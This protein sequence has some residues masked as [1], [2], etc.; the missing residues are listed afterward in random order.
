MFSAVIALSLLPCIAVTI[1]PADL[2]RLLQPDS[3]LVFHNLAELFSITVSL[4]I[5][6]AAWYTFDQSR[7]QHVLFLG[8]AF[9]VIALLDLMHTLSFAGMPAFATPNS[10]DKA[11]EF[12]IM[13][14]LI[15]AAA[16]LGSAFILPGPERT[17]LSKPALMTS[18][19][20]AVLLA[21]T[22]IFLFPAGLPA[23]YLEGSG[24]T[25][26]KKGAE[27]LIIVL[28]AAAGAFYW[29]RFRRTGD[30]VL[31]FFLAALLLSIWSELVLVLRRSVYDT[32]TGLGHAY[33]VIAFF[34][35]YKG[36]I[37]ASVIR[38]YARLAE[39]GEQLRLDILKRRQI[40]EALGA[41]KERYR[42]IAENV[43][44]VIWTLDLASRKFSYVSPSVM[45]L[46]GYS[47]EEV[48][49]QP[50]E[51]ILTPGSLALVTDRLDQLISGLANGMG[52]AAGGPLEVEQPC[53]DGSTVWTEVS[54]SVVRD[55][56][57]RPTA[58]LGISRNITERKRAEKAL[59]DSEQR[60]RHLV[61]AVTDS[62]YSARVENGRVVE[63]VHSPGCR[64]ITGYGPE[65][66]ASDPLF[67]HQVVHPEDREAVEAHMG[68]L[69]EHKAG[70]SFEH[71]IVHLDGSIRWIK[72]TT[73]PRYDEQG[74]LAGWD[75]LI[76]DITARKKLEEQLR[77][78]QKM[79]AIGQLAGGIAHDF[80]NILSAIVG[81]GSLLQMRIGTDDAQ[82]TNIDQILDAA[83]RASNLTHSL[84]AFSR[85]QVLKQEPVDL[86]GIVRRVE[87]LLRRIMGE[88]VDIRTRFWL[89]KAVV[90]ADRGQIEQVLMNLA[91]NA[92]DAMPR[93]G[94]F[95][96]ETNRA[97]VDEAFLHASGIGRPG[98]F[99]VLSVS[100]TGIGM[101]EA[102]RKKVF[103]PFF[104]TKEPGK[105]TGLGLAMVYGI[106][107]QHQGFLTMESEPGQ[108][109]SCRIYV[110]L[111]D[112]ALESVM[113]GRRREPAAPPPTGT[114][115]VLVAED[116]D[117]LRELSGT[118]LRES[119]YT[120]I[121]A[122]DGQEAVDLFREHAG[123]IKMVLLDMIMPKMSG[124]DAFQEIRRINADVKAL[125]LSGY[126]ADNIAEND[127]L[128]RQ[129]DL[130]NKPVVPRDLLTK[131][132]EVLDA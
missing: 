16:L 57:G 26:F 38:P 65:R 68:G 78:A 13:A 97:E 17:W 62:I 28:L 102:T 40:E 4:S 69:L 32:Y 1:F 41:S 48:M 116:D 96:I 80:N 92:R 35:I 54:T 120:V 43:S 98:T 44:D 8:A 23:A 88:D 119:G 15:S 107:E 52:L 29:I 108:G 127:G 115:T 50:L 106:V 129:A 103:E 25:T 109:T 121:P 55:G 73:A 56:Q 128:I 60:Y 83:E 22:A 113:L 75:G 123:T 110:P 31:L 105:G 19:V 131:V 99:A 100:D 86:N 3:C 122:R 81:Y 77:Q 63:T 49:E 95:L 34:L 9:L 27:Y 37:S 112:P 130:I 118:L 33:K 72:H 20:A 132:R 85:K 71:R 21:F 24:L 53:K 12:W 87:K 79:E 6:G 61:E 104:T 111:L 14:R 5:F 51:R 74:K 11:T 93:G 46:R 42:L 82:R 76:L 94:S 70:G 101:D 39:T 89:D 125:F 117:C 114:E 59:L 45:K 64:S 58:I 2:Y 18:A 124:R 10:P 47:P 90:N 36:I 126:T 91:A 7:D 66:F 30:R 84:L 67:W